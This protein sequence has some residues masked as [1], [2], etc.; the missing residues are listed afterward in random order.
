MRFHLEVFQMDECRTAER[1]LGVPEALDPRYLNGL[2]LSSSLSLL[3]P[4]NMYTFYEDSNQTPTY[5]LKY[6]CFYHHPE[7]RSTL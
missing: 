6:N 3:S 1:C 4:L 5:F 2:F 7:G